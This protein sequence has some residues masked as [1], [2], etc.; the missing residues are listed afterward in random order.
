MF[1]LARA[2]FP[3]VLSYIITR[4]RRENRHARV[5]YRE[6]FYKYCTHAIEFPADVTTL[7]TLVL[8]SRRQLLHSPSNSY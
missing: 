6:D 5:V 8:H 2:S 1:L 7:R 4:E 3:I